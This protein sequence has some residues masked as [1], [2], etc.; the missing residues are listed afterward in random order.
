MA[1]L[2][3]DNES[4]AWMCINC[5]LEVLVCLEISGTTTVHSLSFTQDGWCGVAY[6]TVIASTIFLCNKVLCNSYQYTKITLDLVLCYL[7]EHFGSCL[8]FWALRKTFSS[9]QWETN[10]S[11]WMGY[12]FAQKEASVDSMASL[13]GDQRS[14]IATVQLYTLPNIVQ[15]SF[16]PLKEYWSVE[17]HLTI[18]N[19]TQ[20]LA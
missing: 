5:E 4:W 10:C 7:E 17:Y 18:T 9:S 15:N 11:M 2:L 6:S 3:W 19:I 20:F 8:S 13:L 16:S 12:T 14:W 1:V